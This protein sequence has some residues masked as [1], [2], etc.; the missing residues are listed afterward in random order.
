V[1]VIGAALDSIAGNPRWDSALDVIYWLLLMCVYGGLKKPLHYPEYKRQAK[2][3]C[4]D[5]I[6]L[7]SAPEFPTMNVSELYQL[8]E[9]IQEEVEGREVLERYRDLQS[10]LQA[11]S[12]AQQ[13]QP[14]ES[15]KDELI[16]AISAVPLESLSTEQVEFL[17]KLGIADYV[18]RD[19][20]SKV[21]D[22]LIRNPIDIATAAQKFV[23]ISGQIEGG[24]QR[25]DQ[26][27]ESLKDLVLP[28]PALQQR[29]LVRVTFS[30][31][32]AIANVVDLKKWSEIW[33]D[34][35]RGVAMIN[36]SSPEEVEVVGAG[37]GSVVLELAVVYGIAATISA[38]I[39]EALKVTEKVLDIRK[40][41]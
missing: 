25:T 28:E 35:G 13:K 37:R 30:N 1:L 41:A 27:Q 16:R 7:H 17:R 21:E 34:I 23:E 3:L 11:N 15:Q 31:Q 10:V 2:T 14:F 26:L 8:C 29:V 4:G 12:R 32:A 6:A 20:V 24:L 40:K 36:D 22:I 33:Y 19:G 9:W 5:G 39:L 18:G 38:I